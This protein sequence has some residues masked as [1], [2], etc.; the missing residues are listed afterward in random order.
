MPHKTPHRHPQ[1]PHPLAACA[2]R[3]RAG[4][5]RIR[6][7][8]AG[9]FDAPRGAMAGRGPWR[10]SAEGARRVI[11]ANATRTAD[12]LIDFEH[13]ALR[14][15]DNGL[16]VPASGWI[17]PRS[18][19]FVADGDEPGLYGAVTWTAEAAQ[20]IAA[21]KYRYLSPVFPYDPDTGEVLDLAHVA[22]TNTPA[23]D[24]PM[25]AALSAR[26][27]AAFP[28]GH[29]GHPH[30][31]QETPAVNETLKALLAALG[32]PADT[33][34]GDALAG[35]AALKT[36]ADQAQSQ[37]AALSAATPDP[38]KFVPIAVVQGLQ[39]NLAA[40]SD[41]LNSREVDEVVEA[42]L[43]AGKLLPAQ[44]D[45]ATDLGK[46]NLAAL[47]QFVATAHP[48]AALAGTQTGGAAP[49]GADGNAQ[50]DA[51]LAVCRALGLSADE[52]T[53]AKMGA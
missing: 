24:E 47:K 43:S 29:S 44:K 39:S 27:S 42:A 53:K 48:I 26:A 7:I 10:L 21:D 8:P 31:S 12:I 40:L 1:D 14:A 15:A 2:L 4:D 17:D 32:L 19:S 50:T 38:A 20:M 25:L 33:T 41:R 16:P 35:V 23:I 45:W 22:L 51:Q 3:V 52:F 18:L 13:Q 5:A 30:P 11:A 36:R 6:L 49:G 37:L 34:E 28:T 9:Q 46:S